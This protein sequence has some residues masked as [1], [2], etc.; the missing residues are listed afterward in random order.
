MTVVG[1]AI[2]EGSATA[3]DEAVVEALDEVLQEAGGALPEEGGVV[4]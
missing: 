2:G 1:S 3:E 4:V